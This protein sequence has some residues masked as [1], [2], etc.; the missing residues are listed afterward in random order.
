MTFKKT[1]EM[2]FANKRLNITFFSIFIIFFFI[3]I[4]LLFLRKY[5][6]E[7]QVLNS[8]RYKN[9]VNLFEIK[10]IYKS[11]SLI[12]GDSRFEG[13]K[14]N[15]TN[16]INLSVGGETSKTMFDRIKSYEFRDS[17]KIIL[18]I[19]LNDVLF[20]YKTKDIRHNIA[21]LIY[22]ISSKTNNSEIYLCKI[23]PINSS[24]F[25]YNKLDVNS[26]IRNLNLYFD[27]IHIN[28][29]NNK[30][31]LIDFQEFTNNSNELKFRYS[32][33]GIHLNENGLNLFNKRIN[34]FL[35]DEE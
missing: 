15:L 5:H 17:I 31:K 30:K 34:L 12:L 25:F 23:L 19:G 3:I 33:D 32:Y 4:Y 28:S 16:E 2:Y 21:R 22:Q 20:S 10:N 27:S 13:L 1:Y 14:T 7:Y 24:G 35:K 26:K 8:D 29:N 9:K 11:S 18:G 6:L